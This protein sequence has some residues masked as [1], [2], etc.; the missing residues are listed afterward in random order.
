MFYESRHGYQFAG[1]NVPSY[2]RSKTRRW[3]VIL[4]RRA[5]RTISVA[6][7]G[8]SNCKQTFHGKKKHWGVAECHKQSGAE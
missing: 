2:Y 4:G 6:R 3:I 1:K 7:F 8:R 5:S